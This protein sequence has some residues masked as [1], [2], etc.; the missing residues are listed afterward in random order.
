MSPSLAERLQRLGNRSLILGIAASALALI[1]ACFRAQQFFVSYLFAYVFWFGLTIGCVLIAMI[2]HLTGGKWGHPVRR[3]LEAGFSTLPVMALLFI[4]ILFGLRE[5]YPWA[6]SEGPAEVLRKQHGYLNMGFFIVRV[7]FYFAVWLLLTSRLRRRSIEQDTTKDPEP[8]HRLRTISGPGLVIIP[9]T[10]TFAYIDWIMSM[11]PRWHS[12]IFPI[13]ILSGQV[14][15]AYS[16]AVILL[17][18]FD[19]EQSL[20]LTV[21]KLH[22]HQ[23]GNFLLTFVMFWTYVAFGQL[24]IIYSGNTPE[25]IAW[26]L[27][28]ISGSWIYLVLV[29]AV[30][31]FFLPF[32]LLLFRTVKRRRA[33]LASLAML[34]LAVHLIYT[35]WMITPSIFQTGFHLSWLDFVTPI[36]IGGLWVAAFLWLLQRAPLIPKNDPRIQQEMAYAEG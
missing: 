23:L 7:V 11:E 15:A 1:G 10:A 34:L 31:H 32:L 14:L 20:A 22:F 21:S 30:F 3:F 8:G 16:F 27:H 35:F 17:N 28:R 13:I 29:I 33:Y 25:E 26:Y 6:R 9:I 24:L 5:L 4:P 2:H 18:A 36:G 12:T 19:K